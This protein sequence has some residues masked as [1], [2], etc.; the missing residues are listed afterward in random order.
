[1]LDKKRLLSQAKKMLGA[2]AKE[3]EATRE[4]ILANVAETQRAIAA[5]DAQVDALRNVKDTERERLESVK[6]KRAELQAKLRGLEEELDGTAERR[7]VDEAITAS[8]A[9]VRGRGLDGVN[10]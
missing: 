4:A 9:A 3:K 10:E 5:L 6:A 7:R 1:M 8:K 2:L